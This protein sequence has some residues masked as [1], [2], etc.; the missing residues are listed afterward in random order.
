MKFWD[1]SREFLVEKSPQSF[2]K[3]DLLQAVF[4]GARDVKFIIIIK[5]SLPLNIMRLSDCNY[6]MICE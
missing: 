1:L 4:A 2:L 5:V 6:S 3:I